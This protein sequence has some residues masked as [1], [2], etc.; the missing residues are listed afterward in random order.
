MFRTDSPYSVFVKNKKISCWWILQ[1]KPIMKVFDLYVF[2]LMKFAVHTS[3]GNQLPNIKTLYVLKVHPLLLGLFVPIC[4]RYLKY[5]QKSGDNQLKTAEP[6]YW[7]FSGV[8]YHG[9]SSSITF[10]VCHHVGGG[11]EDTHSWSATKGGTPYQRHYSGGQLTTKNQ[12]TTHTSHYPSRPVETSIEKSCNHSQVYQKTDYIY[13]TSSNASLSLTILRWE[14]AL[15]IWRAIEIRYFT[16]LPMRWSS[17]ERQSM[18]QRRVM[19]FP[20]LSPEESCTSIATSWKM[21]RLSINLQ[22]FSIL[23]VS[24]SERWLLGCIRSLDSDDWVQEHPWS[25]H[26]TPAVHPF[27][28]EL[29]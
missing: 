22:H 21:Y 9:F 28:E 20:L 23:R 15:P 2:E 11:R 6:C 25:W 4:S 19:K 10:H 13:W 7:I 18:L 12:P 3:T 16:K 5:E 26:P 14:D 1:Q 27:P 8:R 29:W 24:A 17:R